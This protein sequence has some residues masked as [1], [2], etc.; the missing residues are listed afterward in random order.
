M[1]L[2]IEPPI[3]IQDTDDV[4]HELPTLEIPPYFK[5]GDEIKVVVV[6]HD[7]V[8]TTGTG[9]VSLVIKRN[10][11]EVGD[12]GKI[13]TYA[14]PN[15]S[16]R[17]TFKFPAEAGSYTAE[18]VFNDK[19]DSVYRTKSVTTQHVDVANDQIVTPR[20]M[21]KT[22][23]KSLYGLEVIDAKMV[24]SVRVSY[25]NGKADDY[26]TFTTLKKAILAEN[27][28]L[29][30]G[31]TCISIGEGNSFTATVEFFN[32]TTP[33]T[34]KEHDNNGLVDWDD[35]KFDIYYGN[36][37]DF[38]RNR[39]WWYADIH[40]R[41]DTVVGF[42]KAEMWVHPWRGELA[43]KGE[44]VKVKEFASL[45]SIY[46]LK[47]NMNWTHHAGAYYFK[48]FKKN[49][50]DNPIITSYLGVHNG[51]AWGSWA[52]HVSDRFPFGQM[53]I[54]SSN[55]TSDVITADEVK[56]M[57]PIGDLTV[58]YSLSGG[59]SGN[60]KQAFP[61]DK[62][63]VKY[64]DEHAEMT[65]DLDFIQKEDALYTLT[66][67]QKEHL[68]TLKDRYSPEPSEYI[69]SS[70]Q[71]MRSYDN[72]I[73]PRLKAPLTVYDTALVLEDGVGTVR[74][75]ASFDGLTA[76]SKWITKI[77]TDV[78]DPVQYNWISHHSPYIKTEL[79]ED[80]NIHVGHTFTLIQAA[81]DAKDP[82]TE[83]PSKEVELP[84]VTELT[85]KQ[86]LAPKFYRRTGDGP[87]DYEEIETNPETGE[88]EIKLGYSKDLDVYVLDSNDPKQKFRQ[89]KLFFYDPAVYSAL[90]PAKSMKG[91]VPAIRVVAHDSYTERNVVKRDLLPMGNVNGFKDGVSGN[92]NEESRT[93][94]YSGAFPASIT[95]NRIIGYETEHGAVLPKDF[96]TFH[97]LKYTATETSNQD[98]VTIHLLD[99]YNIPGNSRLIM[100]PEK[101]GGPNKRAEGKWFALVE[102]HESK[103]TGITP[104]LNVIVDKYGNRTPH[105]SSLVSNQLALDGKHVSVLTLTIDQSFPSDDSSEN[106]AFSAYLWYKGADVN[107]T[108]SKVNMFKGREDNTKLTANDFGKRDEHG[109]I[110]PSNK[111]KY[112]LGSDMT[113]IG[114]Y[115]FQVNFKNTSDFPNS[116]R[117]GPGTNDIPE[118]QDP[119]RVPV[120]NQIPLIKALDGDVEYYYNEDCIVQI[121]SMVEFKIENG[122]VVDIDSSKIPIADPNNVLRGNIPR[123]DIQQIPIPAGGT[124]TKI[125]IEEHLA[126]GYNQFYEPNATQKFSKS[127]SGLAIISPDG[128]IMNYHYDD[129]NQNMYFTYKETKTK[130][131]PK[132][133]NTQAFKLS[134]GVHRIVYINKLLDTD[135]DLPDYKFQPE[136]QFTAKTTLNYLVALE[137]LRIE[138]YK[139]NVKI[140][141]DKIENV[142]GDGYELSRSGN[143]IK[144]NV[145]IEERTRTITSVIDFTHM[146]LG[147]VD[148]SGR[149][150][151][152]YRIQTDNP[153]DDVN[154]LVYDTSKITV[155]KFDPNKVVKLRGKVN[156]VLDKIEHPNSYTDAQTTAAIQE[157]ADELM[158]VRFGIKKEEY[159]ITMSVRHI[160]PI[161]GR[162]VN[163]ANESATRKGVVSI[164]LNTMSP[165]QPLKVILEI[166]HELSHAFTNLEGAFRYGPFYAHGVRFLENNLINR[167]LMG[168]AV[169]YDW[170]PF[171]N[172]YGESVYGVGMTAE[173]ENIHGVQKLKV[174]GYLLDE[175]IQAQ[176]S[177]SE[178]RRSRYVT[179]LGAIGGDL[180][181]ERDAWLKTPPMDGGTGLA[182]NDG[183]DELN[184]TKIETDPSLDDY[185]NFWYTPELVTQEEIDDPKNNF[186]QDQLGKIKPIMLKFRLNNV[187]V[188]GK[189][190]MNYYNVSWV[191]AG[192]SLGEK[193]YEDRANKMSLLGMYAV[194]IPFDKP[195]IVGDN[196]YKTYTLPGPTTTIE[197]VVNNKITDFAPTGFTTGAIFIDQP[198]DDNIPYPEEDV[199]FI[200]NL[201]EDGKPIDTILYAQIL[202]DAGMQYT[203]FVY[204][205][206]K[207]DE[208]I[209]LE[210]SKSG[211]ST[212]VA[213]GF[214]PRTF[215]NTSEFKTIPR[216][217]A[218]G[219][220]EALFGRSYEFYSQVKGNILGKVQNLGEFAPNKFLTVRNVVAFA[221]EHTVGNIQVMKP[222]SADRVE[223]TVFGDTSAEQPTI[224]FSLGDS[225]LEQLIG[226][227]VLPYRVTKSSTG[228]YNRSRYYTKYEIKFDEPISFIDFVDVTMTIVLA[229]MDDI[230]TGLLY[231]QKEYR[232]TNGNPVSNGDMGWVFP[233]TETKPSPPYLELE[234]DNLFKPAYQPTMYPNT[235]DMV[236][237][238]HVHR[239]NEDTMKLPPYHNNAAKHVGKRY[240]K[241][242]PKS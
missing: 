197:E 154:N 212:L 29:P 178:P 91:R 58:Y 5:T 20:L 122:A 134:Q 186:T 53:T 119:N 150:H 106:D 140:D 225:S 220:Q 232:D 86:D 183:I 38:T 127:N 144:V 56:A 148:D 191:M 63:S 101:V 123:V 73:I 109:A 89:V 27:I 135:K 81:Y 54:S 80:S 168:V 152:R 228:V 11:D 47:Y 3:I 181:S 117:I 208:E 57:I 238:T 31:D 157:V 49:D 12:R 10:G 162:V 204:C 180:Q 2:E 13:E 87:D 151:I 116:G 129:I 52:H 136:V 213:K 36:F 30:T 159:P 126:N 160:K 164:N 23:T 51:F 44:D 203:P 211:N 143:N 124:S 142:S 46:D 218:M 60:V 99:P 235:S 76:E 21:N 174:D 184:N 242:K 4:Y 74:T 205:R 193:L 239:P 188:D 32:T 219:N 103:Y 77:G 155:L 145:S 1:P 95:D 17:I 92:G 7:N 206:I 104:P 217:V 64:T 9:I 26:Y 15:T 236:E 227:S 207:R 34:S 25:T 120:T 88:Q 45:N 167:Y 118:Y 79:R 221:N 161:G 41:F 59:A 177:I 33:V 199:E 97:K 196:T 14:H 158:W 68:Y 222:S 133:E 170:T 111:F 229:D 28:A 83:V 214:N 132:G 16:E 139:D 192:K 90:I 210:L 107:D 108:W 50:P 22:G 70:S 231:A 149:Y 153:N 138:L 114:T 98:K 202:T 84:V 194:G 112:G 200:L 48:L 40:T 241:L 37:E 146:N 82:N 198:K 137:Q 189:R 18:V 226:N 237:F 71:S 195:H 93:N 165:D 230:P 19:T 8:R 43:Q 69:Y 96:G 67:V 176:Y 66:Y 182:L 223:V 147:G 131:I 163:G 185:K 125:I 42:S 216:T 156:A 35:A 175:S 75:R 24:K 121:A 78:I 62:V 110:I 169:D 115:F 39:Y 65:L 100:S 61:T 130:G 240:L 187:L 105:K 233:L 173:T 113:K 171:V 94:G 85:S 166:A 141:L 234:S 201:T 172:V 128:E 224:I 55:F 72:R 209:D 179:K 6:N 102:Y 215:L 190:G